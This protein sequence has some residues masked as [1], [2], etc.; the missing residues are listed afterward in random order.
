MQQSRQ[1]LKW[2][3]ERRILVTF[4]AAG[5]RARLANLVRGSSRR[6]TTMTAG[7]RARSANIRLINRR[8][9]HLGLCLLCCTHT[10][11][12]RTKIAYN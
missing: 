11:N 2:H 6:I 10:A 8:I 3:T 12:E 5:L 7:H 4:Y 9:R 1:R